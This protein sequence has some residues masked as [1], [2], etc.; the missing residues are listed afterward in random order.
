MFPVQ[1]SERITQ[2]DFKHALTLT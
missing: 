2:F 1:H